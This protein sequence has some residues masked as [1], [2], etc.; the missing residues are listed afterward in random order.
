MGQIAVCNE[1]FCSTLSHKS[2]CNGP[3]A[4]SDSQL[5]T[6]SNGYDSNGY[7]PKC[8]N[9]VY[10]NQDFHSI[11]GDFI[12]LYIFKVAYFRPAPSLN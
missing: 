7:S 3:H 5:N 10:R 9:N 4:S 1:Q 2:F 6:H 8:K 12:L 11:T